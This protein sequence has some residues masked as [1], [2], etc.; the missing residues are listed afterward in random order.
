MVLLVYTAV[1]VFDICLGRL[2]VHGVVDD[3]LYDLLI[4][5]LLFHLFGL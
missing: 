3:S 4:Y 2:G 5:L 1:L